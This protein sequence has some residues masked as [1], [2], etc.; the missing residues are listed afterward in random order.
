[1]PRAGAPAAISARVSA[2]NGP[3]PEQQEEEQEQEQEEGDEMKAEERRKMNQDNKC[4][5]GENARWRDRSEESGGE[6]D[7]RPSRATQNIL[8][9]LLLFPFFALEQH[10]K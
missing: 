9:V 5:S 4:T 3:T 6:R 10:S 2:V 8:P 7:H 1:M